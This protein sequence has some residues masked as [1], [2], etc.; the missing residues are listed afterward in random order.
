MFHCIINF[1]TYCI[2]LLFIIGINNFF[3]FTQYLSANILP[4]RLSGGISS[5]YKMLSF[6]FT[7]EQKMKIRVLA[8]LFA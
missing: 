2:V 8:L 4:L 7:E 1:Y 5:G 3:L 6:I